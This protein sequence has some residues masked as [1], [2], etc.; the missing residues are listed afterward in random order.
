M[1]SDLQKT[2][3][4]LKESLSYRYLPIVDHVSSYNFQ[5]NDYLNLATNTAL[6]DAASDAMK[7]YGFG[8][9]GSRLLSGNYDMMT[10]LEESLATFLGKERV[11]VFN[12]GFQ[13]NSG[14]IPTLYGKNDLIIADKYCHASLLDG[15]KFSGATIKRFNHNDMAHLNDLLQ[16][17][18][19]FYK[20]CLIVTESLFSMDGDRAP[21]KSF[22]DL[23]DKHYADT[24]V[25]EAHSLGVLG[26][27]GRGLCFQE[28][29]SPTYI[30]GTFGKAMGSCGAF[31]AASTIV[32]DYLINRCR[33]FIYTTALPVPVIAATNQALALIQHMDSERDHLHVTARYFTK[34][35]KQKGYDLLGDHHILSLIYPG[36]RTL[37]DR[38][39]QLKDAGIAVSAIRHPT[40]PK[41][42][43]RFR[44]SLKSSHTKADIDYVVEQF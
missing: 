19:S 26:E 9:T 43:E 36:N 6:F 22:Q 8:S 27:A 33:A 16:K 37:L 23:A 30:V 2:L 44:F 42:K 21:L 41:G 39:S 40:V 7:H 17:H 29:V 12:S 28:G 15:I 35:M 34:M 1:E 4:T 32:C 25:D 18:R 11:L 14:V 5:S 38:Y 24:M 20:R 13:L 3:A 31:I 10:M